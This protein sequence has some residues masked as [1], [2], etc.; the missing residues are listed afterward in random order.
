MSVFINHEALARRKARLEKKGQEKQENSGVH[1]VNLGG[2]KVNYTQTSV[3]DFM[4]NPEF[5]KKVFGDI[6]K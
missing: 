6:F 4:N 1:N 3:D 5:A 2:G